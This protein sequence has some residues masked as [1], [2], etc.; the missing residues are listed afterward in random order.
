MES[1]SK[2]TQR[3]EQVSTLSFT[4]VDKI[5]SDRYGEKFS[6]YR[7]KWYKVEKEFI[8]GDYP[9]HLDLELTYRCN[10][11]CAICIFSIEDF[12]KSLPDLMDI[13][14]YKRIVDESAEH[15]LPAMQT[16]YYGEPLMRRDLHEMVNY[17]TKKGIMDVFVTTNGSLLTSDRAKE[18]IDAGVSRIHVSIDANSEETYDQQRHK[19]YFN[20]V[21]NNVHDLIKIKGANKLPIIRTSLC[22]NSINEH[23]VEDFIN[24]WKEHGADQVA[25]QEY[26]NIDPTKKAL[27][28]KQRHTVDDFVCLDPFRRLSIRSNG[29]VLPCCQIYGSYIKLGNVLK[30]SIHDIWKSKKIEDLRGMIKERDYGRNPHCNTCALNNTGG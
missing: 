15:G 1:P 29:D 28:P 24:Y 16:S 4:D 8:S 14:I 21:L 9:L 30:E 11:K 7:K 6:E 23:E 17:A 25:I 18:L 12:E 22:K 19:G 27:F 3:N 2:Y 26:V 5:L 20:R 10:Y 13:D